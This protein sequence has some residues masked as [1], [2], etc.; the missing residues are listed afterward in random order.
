MDVFD[1]DPLS[2]RSLFQIKLRIMLNDSQRSQLQQRANQL[3]KDLVKFTLLTDNST[4]IIDVL[5]SFRER[6]D[7]ME[8]I[9]REYYDIDFPEGLDLQKH[10]RTIFNE[11]KMLTQVELSAISFS[12]S[13]NRYETQ[14]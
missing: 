14:K 12:L 1:Q 7:G 5:L 2:L 4:S 8:S 6:S 10:L 13:N 3:E 9:R 11:C